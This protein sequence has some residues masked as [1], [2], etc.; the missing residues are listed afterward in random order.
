M[1]EY[2]ILVVDDDE[3]MR[4]VITG[5]LEDS[6]PCTIRNAA[7]GVEALLEIDRRKPD[8]MI[9]DVMMPRMTGWE[10]LKTIRKNPLFYDIV[11][12]LVTGVGVVVNWATADLYGAND[13]IDK[14]FEPKE[15]I[16]K[17]RRLLEDSS[18]EEDE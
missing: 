18:E 4:L 13:T 12:L 6:I 17:A 3:D 11:V 5:H 15:L 10:V 14:P 8:L 2:D 7:D 1:D 16:S 9:L